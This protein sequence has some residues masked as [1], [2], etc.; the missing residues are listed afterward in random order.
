[1]IYLQFKRVSG[2]IVSTLGP[3][4][5]S[6]YSVDLYNLSEAGI[7]KL[8]KLRQGDSRRKANEGTS[9]TKLQ[10]DSFGAV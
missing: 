10:M 9:S 5:L 2:R 4:F 1:M 7:R 3:L 8:R 6:M